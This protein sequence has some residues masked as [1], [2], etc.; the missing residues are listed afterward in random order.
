MDDQNDSVLSEQIRKEL[1]KRY[2]KIDDE[3]LN[4]LIEVV[5]LNK[6]DF[7]SV[8]DIQDAVGS[9]LMELNDGKNA[10]QA[11]NDLC[12]KFFEI[13]NPEGAQKG[14]NSNSNGTI[15]QLSAPI[16]I[17]TSEMNTNND[18]QVESMFNLKKENITYVDARKLEKAEAKLKQKL[19]KRENKPVIN[20]LTYDSSK[21]AS[22]SQ[23]ISRKAE[24]Q[25][26]IANKSFDI[27]IENFDV[28]FGN[29]SLLAGANLTL[30]FGR[31]Y[32]LIG[33]N[34]IGK[35]TL[36]KMISSHQLKIPSH[37]RI[38]HVEQEVHGDDTLAI[39]SVLECDEK[40]RSLLQLEK[41]INEK[42]HSEEHKNDTSLNQ[43]LEKV[44]QELEAI[45]AD[46]AISRA[47]KI[48]CGLG[49]STAEQRKATKEFS[50]GWRMR[51]ALARALFAKPDLLLLDEP[52]NMLDLKAIIWLENYL[53][54]W[55]G[56]LLIVSHDRSFLNAVAQEI[57]FL[58][59]QQIE[60]FRGNYEN[61]LKIRSENLK[62]QQREYESQLEYRQHIQVFI[63][64]FRYNA[65]RAAQVQSKIK[66]LEKL[67]ELKP[68]E[69]E[70]EVHFK[71]PDVEWMNGTILRLDEVDFYFSKERYIFK[72]VDISA[73]MDS[74]ICI[75][76]E[77]GAGKTTL[78]KVLIGEYE[79]K[80]GFRQTHRALRLGYFTQHHIDGL[81][82]AF[83]SV[84][85]MQEKFPGRPI[86]EYRAELGKFGV[87]GDMALQPIVSLS[88]GQKS[89]VAFALLSMLNPNFLVLDEPTNHLDMETIEAL[90]EALNKF[91]GGVILVSH[92]ERLIQLICKE[93]WFCRDGQVKSI[94]GGY[95]Q[96][97]K[98]I[99]SELEY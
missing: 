6:D 84:E 89:R 5:N 34:G 38:L 1:L 39:D 35:T 95:D 43:E 92:D 54:M 66:M 29:K 62:N 10:D 28:A 64:R 79:P 76:G 52:T 41:E 59:N 20:V 14:L 19:E 26:S 27:C 37:I 75:V 77:N 45:E 93:L 22:A 49:F 85:V 36:L 58:H 71:F 7:E 90:G 60:P 30:A 2:K 56:T 87:A 94:E 53:Q 98:I 48:L 31:R 40:R 57:L 47:A 55:H 9:I 73:T 8:D 21:L 83:N 3:V 68:I 46:K 13:L 18:K 82:L 74:R 88:G 33:R 80:K 51:L 99:E 81:N 97:R 23:A 67:P 17:A 78:L 25:D 61:F 11:V 72:N 32:C 12:T 96:Y 44:Y 91:G 65:N 63:D 4:Y 86:E 70:K 15:K 50:G 69:K 24:N 42:I 16:Q